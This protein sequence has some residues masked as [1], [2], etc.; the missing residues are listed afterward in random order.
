M[1]PSYLFGTIHVLPQADFILENKVKTAFGE[2]EELVMELDMTDPTLQ[3]RMMEMMT[4]SG[5]VTLDQLLT[6]QQYA[7]LSKKLQTINGMPPLATI[8]SFKP[9]MIATMMLNEFVGSQPA[10]FEMTLMSMASARALPVSGLE[11]IEHQMSIFDSIPYADQVSDLMDMVKRSDEMK[12]LFTSM[13]NQYKAEEVNA[14]YAT[15]AE[16]MDSDAEMGYL[17]HS[18]N[19]NWAEL[20]DTRLG[21]DALFVAVGAAHLGGEKGVIEL[22]RKR[23]YRVTAV[24][25]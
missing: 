7:E 5:G 25:D 2:S 16:Y 22:L 8:N 12:A 1:T 13:V 10:S 23:G 3:A 24:M 21:A 11:T 15:T 19:M 20:L 6:K 9:F 17:L 14:L 18:R 4:M